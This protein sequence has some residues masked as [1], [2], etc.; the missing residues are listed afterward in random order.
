MAKI[1]PNTKRFPDVKQSPGPM[2]YEQQEG[3]PEKGKYTLSTHTGYG[4]RAFDK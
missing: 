4:N 2:T 1:N 3:F